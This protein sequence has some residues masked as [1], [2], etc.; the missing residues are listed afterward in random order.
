MI[1]GALTLDP[2]TTDHQASALQEAGVPSAKKSCI[3]FDATAYIVVV[4]N[5]LNPWTVV[6]N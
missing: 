1:G 3:S 2:N 5:S 4:V 6:T